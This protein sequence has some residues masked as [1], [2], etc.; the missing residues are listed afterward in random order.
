MVSAAK[1]YTAFQ[2]AISAITL[3]TGR[4][5]MM[6]SI[7]PLITLPTTLPRMPSCAMCAAYST[8]TCTATDPMPVSRA[9]ARNRGADGLRAAPNSDSAL[10]ATA[11]STRERFST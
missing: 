10:S 11:P 9:Q 2:E 7:S 4:A 6:P 5:S 1:K 3:A 8:N